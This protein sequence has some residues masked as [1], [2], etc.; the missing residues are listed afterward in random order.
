MLDQNLK[1]MTREFEVI[2]DIPL[3]KV[4]QVVG[5][6]AEQ[7]GY[8]DLRRDIEDKGF[9]TPIVLIRNT[10]ENYELATRKVTKEFVNPYD[11]WQ[12]RDYLCMYGNQRI[13]IAIELRIFHLDAIIAD[14]V[15]WSH[16]IKLQLD[17]KPFIQSITPLSY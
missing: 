5:K 12:G 1:I 7:A 11:K 6:R 4:F 16:A 17:A 10:I 15:E 8:E 3:V 2:T 13:N 14:N 9:M